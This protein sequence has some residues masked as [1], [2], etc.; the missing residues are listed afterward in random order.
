[1]TA[2]TLGWAALTI[3]TAFTKNFDQL[4]AIRV[5][6]G[7]VEA[8]ILPCILMYITMTYNRDEY[9]IRNTYVFSA[10]AVSGAFGKFHHCRRWSK[11]TR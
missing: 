5:L 2:S 6:L 1:V 7:M 9:A 10:A 3:G 4:A 11:L 8:A